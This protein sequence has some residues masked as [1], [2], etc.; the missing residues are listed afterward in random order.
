MRIDFMANKDSM[1][2]S[3]IVWQESYFYRPVE[4][5]MKDIFSV[6]YGKT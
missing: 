5:A 4:F 1:L 2:D 6:R 3:R